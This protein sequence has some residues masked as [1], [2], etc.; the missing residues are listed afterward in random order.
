MNKRRLLTVLLAS[1]LVINAGLEIV[2]AQEQSAAERD[3]AADANRI[4]PGRELVHESRE[5]AGEE[6]DETAEF[7]KSPITRAEAP[8]LRS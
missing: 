3:K 2:R 8:S 4:R 5:A 7:K 6:K 1:L